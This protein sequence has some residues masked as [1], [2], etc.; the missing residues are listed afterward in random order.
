MHLL[1]ASANAAVLGGPGIGGYVVQAVGAASSLMFNA[2]TF[3]VSAACLV[4]IQDSEPVALNT[5]QS[6]NVG[7]LRKEITDG[8]RFVF[9]DPYLRP[10]TLWAAVV[11]FG[12]TGYEA[13]AVLFLVRVVHLRAGVIGLL[14]ALSG[15]GA[16]FGSLIAKRVGGR[17]GTA[18]TLLI[19]AF[20]AEPF[21]LL[22]PL[23]G[24]GVRLVFF[25]AGLLVASVGIAMSNVFSASFRQTYPPPE[26]RARTTATS[27][28]LVN[29]SYPLGALLGGGIGT[30]AGIRNGIWIMLGTVV[31]ANA[32]LLTPPLLRQRD[33]PKR[34]TENGV[35]FQARPYSGI[36]DDTGPG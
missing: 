10:I 35:T 25:A 26:M 5:R 36:Y 34:G 15:A 22:V 33:L 8:I 32:F 23:A 9:R 20:A 2:F 24:N 29:G 3:L 6:E 12:L 14:F 27:W 31:L 17:F 19:A 4:G 16:I 28:F 11:N 13:L 1:Q 18:R 7:N 30:W 21:I